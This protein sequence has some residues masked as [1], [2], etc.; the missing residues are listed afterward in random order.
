M[1][2]LAV[3]ALGAV[4][5]W[6]GLSRGSGP[7]EVQAGVSP[8]SSSSEVDDG[9]GGS[10]FPAVPQS[11]P[12][13]SSTPVSL[14]ANSNAS[15]GAELAANGVVARTPETE[16]VVNAA[17][18]AAPDLAPQDPGP[19]LT[20]FPPRKTAASPPA[21]Y[22]FAGGSAPDPERLA[23]LLL[24]A[25]VKEDPADLETYLK[26]GEGADL[27]AAKGQLVAAF[28]EA[29]V[30]SVGP[31][32]ERLDS[33]REAESVTSSQISLLE[34]ALDP[35][36]MR[37]VPRSA[38]AGRVEPLAYAMR[39]ILLENEA[40]SLLTEREYEMSAGAWSD[41][42][43]MEVNAP[44]TPHRDALLKWA[45]DLAQVQS[46]HRYSP[47]GHWPFIEEKVRA[48]DLGLT[49]VRKRVLKRRPDLLI[50]VGLMRKVNGVGQY[51]H[52]D[53]VLRIPT[54]RAN[55]IV[56]LDSRVLLY[57]HG[58]EVV[59]VWDVGIGKEDHDTPIGEF[60]IGIKQEK[61]AH[62]TKGLP[63]GHPENQLGSRWLALERAGK[64]TSYGIHGTS[65]PNGVGG[66]VSLGCIRMRNSEVEE[67]F[68]LLPRGAKVLIQP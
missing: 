34:A 10:W 40:R 31:A 47:K 16:V 37:A 4:L 28:W 29:L 62:T 45:T 23:T 22:S 57:R 33:I 61:P 68:E 36:G 63:Y 50:C 67:L 27:P 11:S 5:I 39:M 59:Q 46:N 42:I 53:D 24:E 65:D 21:E 52:K 49:T 32:K 1:R 19:E 3:V 51:I 41:L 7:E 20:A 6:F 2:G 9:E 12:L 64:N 14:E 17:P 25:W 55:V 15:R 13:P 56:D 43:Q 38:S 58:D 54:D 60:T 30:G 44:W 8:N 66:R 48:S 26:V 18:V 35:P